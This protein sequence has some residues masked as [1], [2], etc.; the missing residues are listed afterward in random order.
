MY[1][2]GIEVICAN[3]LHAKGRVER[4]NEILQDHLVKEL[5]LRG[6]SNREA[7]NAYLPEFILEFDARCAKSPRDL[8]DAHRQ[9]LE[10]DDLARILIV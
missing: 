6:I 1:Q 8:E 5:R 10:Q 9:L 4:V 7:G 3:T 2:L